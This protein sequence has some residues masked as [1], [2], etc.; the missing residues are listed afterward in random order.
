[1]SCE[2]A[3]RRMRSLLSQSFAG[4]AYEPNKKSKGTFMIKIIRPK[5]HKFHKPKIEALLD[6]FAIYQKLELFEEEKNSTTFMVANDT[7][8]GV[9]GG[10][11]VRQQPLKCL[12]PN[13]AQLISSLSPTKRRVWI[14]N[15]CSTI[16][17]EKSFPT[18][19]QLNL[20]ETFYQSLFKNFVKFGKETKIGFLVI[21][22]L[23]KDY[24]NL[25]AYGYR[26]C[27]FK[28]EPKDSFDGLF[29]G[30]LPLKLSKQLYIE[31]SMMEQLIRIKEKGK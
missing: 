14:V 31:L 1:M 16:E 12:D 9:Y 19:E 6:L 10:A 27:I 15:L 20:C 23:H 5:D 30:I 13:V 29:H 21:K 24:F 22:L 11:L 26:S 3:R 7:T 8:R 18:I 4:F 17:Q 2:N 25:K 28:V